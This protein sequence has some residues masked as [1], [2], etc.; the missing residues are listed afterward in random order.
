MLT[1]TAADLA[2]HNGRDGAAAYVAFEGQ[3]FDLSESF[4]WQRG[5][6]QATHEAGTD[7]TG[8]MRDAPHG[9]EFL[10]RFPVVGTLAE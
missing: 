4:L 9:A 10:E 5:R 7:L 1:F 8:A 6:H 2:R 3:V